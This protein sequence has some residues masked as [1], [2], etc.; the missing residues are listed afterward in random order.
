MRACSLGQ[1]QGGWR[2]SK[3]TA[4]RLPSGGHGTSG[5]ED[6]GPQPD[7]LQPR[8]RNP[9]F[10]PS[11]RA[12]PRPKGG[13]AG[14]AK[15][16]L[17]RFRPH[18]TICLPVGYFPPSRHSTRAPGNVVKP[19]R[20]RFL[21]PGEPSGFTPC[22]ARISTAGARCGKFFFSFPGKMELRGESNGRPHAV[23]ALVAR[24]DLLIAVET[25]GVCRETGSP[26]S[27]PQSGPKP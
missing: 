18:Q 13:G 7:R 5:C 3:P 2:L 6:C 26:R 22:P 19:R 21:C 15:K 17:A 20:K 14:Q 11:A 25:G 27:A 8:A 10:C 1:P 23:P 9:P 24:K 4:P 12:Y 16:D